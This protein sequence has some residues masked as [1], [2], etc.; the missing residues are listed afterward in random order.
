MRFYALALLFDCFIFH[1]ILVGF[2]E[3]DLNIK[4]KWESAMN[5]TQNIETKIGTGT[6]TVD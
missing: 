1:R 3:T 6:G 5:K 4:G 2:R